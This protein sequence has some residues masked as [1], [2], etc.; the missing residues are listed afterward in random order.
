MARNK[1]NKSGS[2]KRTADETSV[3]D[4]SHS[5]PIKK[6]KASQAPAIR[7]KDF[8]IPKLASAGPTLEERRAPTTVPV[9]RKV[10]QTPDEPA[11][12]PKPR[13]ELGARDI[14]NAKSAHNEL[15]RSHEV[16]TLSVISSSSIQKIVTGIVEHLVPAG[17]SNKGKPRMVRIHVWASAAGKATSIVEIAKRELGSRKTSWYQ[18]TAIEAVLLPFISKDGDASEAPMNTEAPDG[19]TQ[20]TRAEDEEPAANEQER[21]GDETDFEVMKAQSPGKSAG[22]GGISKVRNVPRMWIF[23]TSKPVISL[24]RSY[25]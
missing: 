15:E 24:K 4:A 23:L 5:R 8:D 6:S 12:V 2:K 10:I 3:S 9:A 14:R 7:A 20:I 25:G 22:G 17:K 19:E 13:I 18:Y 16:K 11:A 1:S 21:E